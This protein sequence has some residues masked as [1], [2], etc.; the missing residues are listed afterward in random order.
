MLV[1]A[2]HHIPDTLNDEGVIVR[3]ELVDD[4]GLLMTDKLAHIPE[5]PDTD[6]VSD[7]AVAR[8]SGAGPDLEV[9]IAEEESGPVGPVLL[10]Q[11]LSALGQSG[12]GYPDTGLNSLLRLSLT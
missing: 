1:C 7:E 2:D 5:R 9:T 10:H 4:V 12:R 3:P 11:P 8:I 6:V